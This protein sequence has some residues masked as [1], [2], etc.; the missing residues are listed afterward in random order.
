MALC[1]FGKVSLKGL[2]EPLWPFGTDLFAR[3]F[4]LSAGETEFL[5]VA[6]DSLCTLPKETDRFREMVSRRTGLLQDHIWYHELQLHAAPHS[7]QLLG[8]CMDGIAKCIADAVFRLREKAQAFQC[9]VTECDFGMRYSM[10]R[11]QYVAGLGGVTIWTG[12]EF[13]EK[14]RPQ[15]THPERMLLRGYKPDLPVFDQPVPFDLPVDPKAYLFV[16]RNEA[17]HVIGTLSRFAA[18]PDVAVLFEHHPISDEVREKQYH[19]DFDWPGTLS[20]RLEAYFSA[21]SLYINGPCADLAVKKGYGTMDTYEGSARECRRIGN[22]LAEALLAA[23]AKKSVPLG[24]ADNLKALQFKVELPMQ[25]VLPRSLS[26]LKSWEEKMKAAEDAFQSAIRENAPAYRVKQLADDKWKTDGMP[27]MVEKICG[28]TEEELQKRSAPVTVS[29]LR[30]GDYLF[31]GVPG[32]SLSEMGVWLRS[33]FTGVKTIP[34]DQ[35]NGYYDYMVTPQW[36]TLGG[37]TYWASWI[38]RE[39]IPLLKDEIVK[40][41]DGFLEE[42]GE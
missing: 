29:A 35:V 20:E 38:S 6:M 5:L 10:N 1:S 9:E 41:L 25:S 12:M 40:H 14:N 16:F 13:D 19:Y 21:P 3:L 4:Y 26:E 42:E 24:N 15:S 17:G 36:L 2:F 31:V 34:V 7:E 18:H 32:E 8:D 30:L 28:F 23:H 22:E 37:Y 39:G 11:Q 33:T 27:Y